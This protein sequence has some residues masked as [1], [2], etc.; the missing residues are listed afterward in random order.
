MSDLFDRLVEDYFEADAE[1]LPDGA[2]EKIKA[3]QTIEIVTVKGANQLD[4]ATTVELL[5]AVFS[6][7]AAIMP[8][9]PKK[10]DADIRQQAK[11]IIK[12]KYSSI[13][14]ALSDDELE[15]FVN[16]IV[17]GGRE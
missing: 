15:S 13:G 2:L 1:L 3:G 11:E 8:L 7:I 5:T 16:D 9:L 10:S 17:Q 14:T 6:L 12:K 4:I